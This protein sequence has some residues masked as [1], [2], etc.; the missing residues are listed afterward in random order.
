MKQSSRLFLIPIA[1]AAGSI[2]VLLLLMTP[3]RG[4]SMDSSY[5]KAVAVKQPVKMKKQEIGP[6]VAKHEPYV[7]RWEQ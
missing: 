4:A 3:F 5:D 7:N 6:L 1:V 2:I